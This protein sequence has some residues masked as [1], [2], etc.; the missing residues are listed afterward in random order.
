METAEPVIRQELK[1]KLEEEQ[2]GVKDVV[3]TQ[4]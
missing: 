2:D 4:L 1:K 3:I